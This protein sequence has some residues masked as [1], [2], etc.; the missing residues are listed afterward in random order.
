M[1]DTVYEDT[2][3]LKYDLNIQHITQ[4]LG[5][6]QCVNTSTTDITTTLPL[7][8]FG[9][10]GSDGSGARILLLA[11]VDGALGLLAGAGDVVTSEAKGAAAA[12]VGPADRRDEAC[13]GAASSL[14]NRLVFWY[15]L[16][17]GWK[18]TQGNETLP[19]HVIKYPHCIMDGISACHKTI[20]FHQK[21][22]CMDE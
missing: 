14:P 1:N 22:E 13:C 18:N 6:Q 5:S 16:A 3:I 8:G 4:H 12:P 7:A 15:G 20:L 17:A 19:F 2:E 10:A 21:N 9:L 11:G